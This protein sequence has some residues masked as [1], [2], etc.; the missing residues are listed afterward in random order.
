MLCLI[1][2]AWTHRLEIPY[3]NELHHQTT[4]KDCGAVE[5]N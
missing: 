3:G 1:E 2:Y 5:E 4:G